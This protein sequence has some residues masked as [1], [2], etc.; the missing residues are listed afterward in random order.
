MSLR[1]LIIALSLFIVTATAPVLQAAT[2]LDYELT[3][4]EKSELKKNIGLYLAN[5]SF[6]GTVPDEATQER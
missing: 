5:I 1:T 3:G 6:S 2:T 4:V